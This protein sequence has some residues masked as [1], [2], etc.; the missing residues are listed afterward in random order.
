[1][2]R[3]AD[4]GLI[5][6][7]KRVLLAADSLAS[8]GEDQFHGYALAGELRRAE[9]HTRVMA[10]ST[11]YRCL[12]RLMERGFVAQSGTE[13]EVSGGPP[14]RVFV[15]TPA[16]TTMARD[17]RAEGTAEGLIWGLA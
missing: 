14:R 17:L 6:N 4:D 8:S 7:E 5:P 11:L 10:Y 1:M 2:R 15:L 9:P 12:A 16:G 3:P 13:V